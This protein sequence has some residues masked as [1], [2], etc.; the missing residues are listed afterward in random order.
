MKLT[1]NSSFLLNWKTNALQAFTFI[2][3]A[4]RIRM[5][6][7]ILKY[8]TCFSFLTGISVRGIN[9]NEEPCYSQGGTCRLTSQCRDANSVKSGL[10]PSHPANVKCCLPYQESACSALG[11]QCMRTDS[12]C[13]GGNYVNGKCSTQ[14]NNVKCCV[15]NDESG[16]TD[17]EG[18][19]GG[20]G[21]DGN[22]E[23]EYNS[24]S[25]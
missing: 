5:L 11:G 16:E 14:P 9:P 24:A 18:D 25:R 13:V 3:S 7:S 10:C 1:L 20:G 22:D 2:K 19:I 23:F 15:S 21:E 4:A 8:L 17:G 12:A 6:N